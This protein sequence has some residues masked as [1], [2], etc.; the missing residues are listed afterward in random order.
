MVERI[1]F[2]G[3]EFIVIDRETWN[4]I[5]SCLDIPDRV[6][7]GEVFSCSTINKILQFLNLPLA[8]T[9]DRGAPHLERILQSLRS[10]YPERY[11]KMLEELFPLATLE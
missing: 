6:K 10:Q 3:H 4:A 7:Y 9:G 11:T 1:A 5:F 2:D 8:V